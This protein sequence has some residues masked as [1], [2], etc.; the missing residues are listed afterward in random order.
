[1]RRNA[2]ECWS[3]RTRLATATM[4]RRSPRVKLH[5]HDDYV[6]EVQD[7]AAMRDLYLHFVSRLTPQVLRAFR[8]LVFPSWPE[9]ATQ[10]PAPEQLAAWAK[11]Y[12]LLKP[13]GSV[14]TWIRAAAAATSAE[15]C[16]NPKQARDSIRK[17]DGKIIGPVWVFSGR[18]APAPLTDSEKQQRESIRDWRKRNAHLTPEQCAQLE[19]DVLVPRFHHPNETEKEFRMR[20]RHLL[21]QHTVTP[22]HFAWAARY[23]AG[24]TVPS[25]ALDARCTRR[26][27]ELAISDVLQSVGLQRRKGKRGRPL[28]A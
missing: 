12:G 13:S 6:P 15:W 4:E 24:E 14:A 19:P 20:S 16:R 27:V 3:L 26:A 17:N 2:L 10:K 8:Q 1:M 18:T 11:Q 21:N 25:I 9:L 22:E 28:S 5:P 7:T 23:Q